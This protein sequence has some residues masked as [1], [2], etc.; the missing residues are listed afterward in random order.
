MT[1]SPFRTAAAALALSFVVA[2]SGNA[3]PDAEADTSDVT[4]GKVTTPA[5]LASIKT[6]F[7]IVMENHNW[8][9]IKGSASAPY[10]N[11]LAAQG[12]HAENYV[13]VPGNHPSEPNYLWMTAGTNFGVTTDAN[14]STNHQSTHAH[15]AALLDKAHVTWKSYQEDITGT[16]CPL[17]AHG[18]FA[19]KHDPFLFYDDE[20]GNRNPNDASCIAHNRPY[21]ELADDLASGS[22]ARFNFITPNLCD[23]MHNDTGCA[24]HDSIKNGDTWLASAV[25]QILAS[26]AYQNGGALFI[27]WDESEH[28]DFPIGMIALS[29]SAK[30]GYAA[31]T[32]YTHS[33]FLRT[34]Q[35]IFAVGP[36]LGDAAHATDLSDMFGGAHAPPTPNAEPYAL[37]SATLTPG[38]VLTTDVS[39]ISKPGYP[40]TVRHV[41]AAEKKQVATEYAFTGASS[42]VEYDHLIS[43]ELGG[44][45]DVTNLWP[46]PIAEAK[47]KDGLEDYLHAKVIEG[48]LPLP[49]VQKRIAA[50]W[51]KLWNDVGQPGPNHPGLEDPHLD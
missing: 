21:T 8:S 35:E 26:Q 37:P 32:K 4:A 44:S 46:Q 13:N 11:Q 33:S 12:A 38:A 7:V 24:T 3:E 1:F 6:V 42:T 23:D 41:T 51:V 15:L 47:V 34:L 40:A 5:A 19:P 45:N 25:P 16:A 27:T 18:L 28:G 31:N 30:P 2:C 50:D 20:T 22:V 43:I 48:K 39:V 49:E 29:P 9:D 14:P 10:L 17:T 36:F